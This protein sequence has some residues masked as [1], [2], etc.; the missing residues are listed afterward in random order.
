MRIEEV[1]TR[2]RELAGKEFEVLGFTS[3]VLVLFTPGLKPGVN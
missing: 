1:I 3:K 2:S